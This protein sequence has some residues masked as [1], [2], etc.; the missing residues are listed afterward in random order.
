MDRSR[1]IQRIDSRLR[2][3]SDGEKCEI[4]AQLEQLKTVHKLESA[5]E[6]YFQ[7]RADVRAVLQLQMQREEIG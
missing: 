5:L 1:E 4:A 2:R 6:R 7:I 3:T